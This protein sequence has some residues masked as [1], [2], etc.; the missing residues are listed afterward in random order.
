MY[1]RAE[2]DGEGTI[3][4]VG[5]SVGAGRPASG[6]LELNAGRGVW[7]SIASSTPEGGKLFDGNAAQVACRQLG[8]TSWWLLP[9][10]G[11]WW[12]GA[13][14]GPTWRLDF[15]CHGSEPRLSACPRGFDYGES[16][17]APA[18]SNYTSVAAVHCFDGRFF[19]RGW[20]SS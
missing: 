9:S 14:T 13:S 1:A 17:A 11:Q 10:A 7:V 15:G 16:V 3:R 20:L 4:L 8:W 2:T 18:G 12:A 19:I 5:G 6:I